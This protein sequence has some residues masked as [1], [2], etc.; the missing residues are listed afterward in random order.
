MSALLTAQCLQ[1]VRWHQRTEI[2]Y[3]L[4]CRTARIVCR[5]SLVICQVAAGEQQR[6]EWR[7]TLHAASRSNTYLSSYRILTHGGVQQACRE[8]KGTT[9]LGGKQELLRPAEYQTPQERTTQSC[10]VLAAFEAPVCYCCVP[11][12]AWRLKESWQWQTLLSLNKR[13]VSVHP[14]VLLTFTVLATASR[15]ATAASVCLMAGVTSLSPRTC[16]CLA[17]LLSA[18][19]SHAGD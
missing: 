7:L 19:L 10:K 6:V 14:P 9:R 5:P 8:D 16:V 11:G 12:R 17:S 13:S 18:F 1:L 4:L 2:R 3:W 15:R